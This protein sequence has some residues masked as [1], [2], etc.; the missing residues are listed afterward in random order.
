LE[1]ELQKHHDNI[2]YNNNQILIWPSKTPKRF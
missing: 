1:N 2:N